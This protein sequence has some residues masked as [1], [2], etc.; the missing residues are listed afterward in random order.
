LDR[1]WADLQSKGVA[2]PAL[3]QLYRS[4]RKELIE[5]QQLQQQQEKQQQQLQQQQQ[6]QEDG[7]KLQKEKLKE[8][9]RLTVEESKSVTGDLPHKDMRAAESAAVGG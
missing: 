8:K 2:I 3:E 5:Q 7:D 4:K 9:E 6:Q 1:D